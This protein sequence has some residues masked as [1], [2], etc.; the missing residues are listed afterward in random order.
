MANRL[1]PH[2]AEERY[3]AVYP[4]EASAQRAVEAARTRGATEIAVDDPTDEVRAVLGEQR[5][6]VS[7]AWVGPSIGAYSPEMVRQVPWWTAIGALAGLI[8]SLP[9]GMVEMGG[10]SQAG[11]FAIAALC[12]ATA[13]GTIGF[14][15]GG[16]A[17]SR[18][19]THTPLAGEHGTVV[20]LNARDG[21][22]PVEAL[23]TERPLRVDRL[24]G[25]QATDTVTSGQRTLE[26]KGHAWDIPKD[27]DPDN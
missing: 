5:E 1:E 13:G 23:T 7:K 4:D 12:G 8:L 25:M 6:E 11:R 9:F 26:P 18:R 17:V 20:G 3:V 15:A 27:D 22:G 10:V 24:E 16:F 21:Q 2:D 14:L 19:R